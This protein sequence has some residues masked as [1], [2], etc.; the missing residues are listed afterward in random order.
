[1]VSVCGLPAQS[2]LGL[3]SRSERTIDRARDDTN[4]NY[5][6]KRMIIPIVYSLL[7]LFMSIWLIYGWIVTTSAASICLYDNND[8]TICFEY[9]MSAQYCDTS[10]QLY[11]TPTGG[12]SWKFSLFVVAWHII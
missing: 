11:Q 12:S 10:T 1:M 9:A 2:I 3:N 7:S 6:N 8:W 4:D 5:N